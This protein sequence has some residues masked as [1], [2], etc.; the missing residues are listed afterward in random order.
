MS[1]HPHDHERDHAYRHRRDDGLKALL[2]ALRQLLVEDLQGD[3][4]A[5]AEHHRQ[6]HAN[7]RLCASQAISWD[8]RTGL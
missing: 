8:L 4:D 1:A 5:G 6:H 3:C 2:L 7:G